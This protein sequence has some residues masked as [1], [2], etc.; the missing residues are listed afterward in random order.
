M[1][2]LTVMHNKLHKHLE[3]VQIVNTEKQTKIVQLLTRQQEM[4]HELKHEL[5]HRHQPQLQMRVE[6]EV[7]SPIS[8]ENDQFDFERAGL[9]NNPSSEF[10][11]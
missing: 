1:N 7:K 4:I 10:S 6:E 3:Q 2:Q 5:R 9:L 11:H 8:F